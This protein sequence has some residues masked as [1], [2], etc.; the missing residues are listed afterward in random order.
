MTENTFF[1]AL[2]QAFSHTPTPS[3]HTALQLFSSYL[4][5]PKA[6]EKLFLLKGFAGTGK[7]SITNA[8]IAALPLISHH[9]VLLAPTGRAAKVMTFFTRQPAFT[10][11]KYIYYHRTEGG[12]LA[13]TLR[14]NKAQRTLFIVDEASMIADNEGVFGSRSLLDDLM[15]FVYSGTDCKLLLIGDAAQLP[16]VHTHG[17]PA[18]NIAHLEYQYQKEVVSTQLTDVVRQR[19]RSGI[20]RNATALRKTIFGNTSQPYFQFRIGKSA[21]L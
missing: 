7:T 11:H 14:P 4:F 5:D 13:F 15:R 12:E 17:S 19:R 3:Q 20:L 10:I 1:Q 21:D 16:P 2:L 6:A 8:L 9:S 18:L